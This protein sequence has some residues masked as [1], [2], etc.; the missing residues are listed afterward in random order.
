MKKKL[1]F[2]TVPTV[3]WIVLFLHS[4]FVIAADN[5]LPENP[6]PKEVG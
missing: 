2:R 3:F 4:S 1:Q 6:K 5:P